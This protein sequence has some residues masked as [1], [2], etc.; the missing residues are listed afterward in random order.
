MS[1][2]ETESTLKRFDLKGKVAMVTGGAG[3]L[4][5][6]SGRALAEAGADIAIVD[7]KECLKRSEEIARKLRDTFS[8]KAEAFAADLTDENDARRLCEEIAD[9]MGTIDIVH[10]NVGVPGSRVP[11]IDT[12]LA[13]YRRVID[14]NFITMFLTDTAAARI[15][16][17]DGHGG[18]IINTASMGGQCIMQG[19]PYEVF[20]NSS[21][22]ATKAAALYF[23]KSLGAQLIPYG[24]R[25][26]SI[27]PG[28]IDAKDNTN[29]GQ[30]NNKD[31]DAEA[32]KTMNDSQPIKRTCDVSELM[33]GILYLASEA[34]SYCVG[35]DLLIDGGHMLF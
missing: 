26:N 32:I 11:D 18:S 5:Y 29:G 2:N 14:G 33:G 3:M 21:Y 6:Y 15:M 20:D 16:I 1:V 24:I 13:D 12:P 25:V 27:S 4:G 28:Y 19:A 8:V 9:K 31:H 7:Q 30:M 23:T 22:G 35:T 17:R 34:S 10:S